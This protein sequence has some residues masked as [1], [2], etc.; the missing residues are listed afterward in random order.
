MTETRPCD[1]G[2]R[3]PAVLANQIAAYDELRG[4]CPVALMNHNDA[5]FDQAA[6]KSQ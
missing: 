2:P 3:S 6:P 4:R 5:R 1:W